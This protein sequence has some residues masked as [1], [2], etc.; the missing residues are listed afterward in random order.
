MAVRHVQAEVPQG[1]AGARPRIGDASDGTRSETLVVPVPVHLERRQFEFVTDFMG[2]GE[3]G[4]WLGPGEW[5][6]A[7]T[8]TSTS[9]SAAISCSSRD[10]RYELRITNE[11]E[12]ALFVDRVQLVAV[13]HPAAS[14]VYPE[15]G[16]EGAAAPA[17]RR[18]PP[19]E[20]ARA[21]DRHRR[22]GTRCH[23][24]PRVASTAGTR[25]TSRS[26]RFAGMPSAHTLTLDLGAEADRACC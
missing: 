11:L 20:A 13:D 25:T 23:R 10:G 6:H 2:G 5:E 7:R 3:L 17:V 21:R 9:A 26:T 1:T 18:S 16:I 15:R 4:Y 22:Q 14:T 19:R 8:P 12:E 24:A